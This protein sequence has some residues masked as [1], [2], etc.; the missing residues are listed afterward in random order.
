MFLQIKKKNLYC[1]NQYSSAKC[2]LNRWISFPKAST[3][4]MG[5]LFRPLSCT[6]SKSNTFHST[7]KRNKAYLSMQRKSSIWFIE[8]N[9]KYFPNVLNHCWIIAPTSKCRPTSDLEWSP[10]IISCAV[11]HAFK[12]DYMINNHS[13]LQKSHI[14]TVSKSSW[15]ISGMLLQQT[16]WY[17]KSLLKQ[18]AVK[19]IILEYGE[20]ISCD[21]N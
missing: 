21:G 18:W 1:E 17:N 15:K 14:Y 2:W 9:H 13:E 20:I 6:L 16:C 19:F 10:Y 4:R 7:T 8:I 5:S 12:A 11:K 3:V